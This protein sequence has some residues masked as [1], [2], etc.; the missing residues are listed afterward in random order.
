M[1]L[2]SNFSKSVIYPSIIALFECELLKNNRHNYK[3]PNIMN[4][5]KLDLNN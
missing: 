5:E 2:V 1:K 3:R 4:M